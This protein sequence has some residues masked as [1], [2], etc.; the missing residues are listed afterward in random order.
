VKPRSA[1]RDDLLGAFTDTLTV[2]APAFGAGSMALYGATQALHPHGAR[3]EATLSSGD[4]AITLNHY[5]AGRAIAYG[6]FPGWQ[7]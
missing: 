5:G 6:F 4:A 2:T 7:Y 1:V 3:V